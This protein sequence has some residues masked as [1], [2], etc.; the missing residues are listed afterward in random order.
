MK[1]ILLII[2][3]GIVWVLTMACEKKPVTVTQT[4][5]VPTATATATATPAVH[6]TATPEPTPVSGLFADIELRPE[7][8]ARLDKIVAGIVRDKQRYVGVQHMRSNGMPWQIVG[9]IHERESSR[10]FAKHL[11]EGSPLQHRTFYIPKGRLP[12]PKEPP[13]T[14]EQSSEDALYVLKREDK[15]DWRDTDAALD[16]IEQYN[17]LGYRKYH[18]EVKSPYLYSG[19]TLYSRGKYVADGRFDKLAVDKQAGVVALWKRMSER[20]LLE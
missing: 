7:W 18:P 15:V 6:A 19:S 20:G 4:V 17:G 2:V 13:F 10:S 8:T 16:A 5:E 11:H 14:W 3:G 1:R 9:G 12:A